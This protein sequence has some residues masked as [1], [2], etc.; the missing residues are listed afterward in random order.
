MKRA[1]IIFSL[2]LLSTTAW[3]QPDNDSLWDSAN[4]AYVKGDYADALASY[5]SIVNSGYVSYKLLYNMGNAYFKL[6]DNGKAILYYN[7]ALKLAP[8]DAD[9]QYN[10]RVA[11][12]YVKDNI[13]IIPEFFLLRWMRGLRMSLGSDAWAILSLVLLALMLSAAGLYI[14]VKKVVLRKIGFYT[15]LVSFVLLVFTVI[16]AISARKDAMH[17]AEAIVM[18]SAAPVKS[19][20]DNQSKDIFILHEGTKVSVLSTLDKWAEIQINDGNK[21]WI[22]QSSIENITPDVRTSR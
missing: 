10:L 16:F 5:D 18:S 8:T 14:L 4:T 1:I 11:N 2:L 19:S 20:P 6:G 13:N 22:Q 17:S 7:R 21:G 12:N 15:A 9:I 3:A